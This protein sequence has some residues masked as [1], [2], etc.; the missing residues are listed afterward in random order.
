MP[1]IFL[2]RARSM[3]DIADARQAIVRS[4]SL[5]RAGSM[6]VPMHLQAGNN[7]GDK[8]SADADAPQAVHSH[9]PPTIFKSA[10]PPAVAATAPKQPSGWARVRTLVRIMSRSL[11]AVAA[12]KKLVSATHRR[13]GRVH[14]SETHIVR[15]LFVFLTDA[16]LDVRAGQSREQQSMRIRDCSSISC[17]I[18]HDQ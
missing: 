14:D 3:R 2:D 18:M 1:A 4:S 16:D 13:E 17:L 15:S 5:R 10:P 8:N 11:R 9:L 7:E 12:L 6:V